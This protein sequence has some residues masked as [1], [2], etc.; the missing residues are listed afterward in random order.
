ALP[1]LL[2]G[3]GAPPALHS[4]PTR[5]SSDLQVSAVPDLQS[6]AQALKKQLPDLLILSDRFPA[7]SG[8]DFGAQLLEDYPFLPILLLPNEHSE[9]LPGEA[10]R[11]GFAGYLKPPLRPQQAQQVIAQTLERRRKQQAWI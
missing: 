6:A 4:F 10:L 8:L 5:R 11:R 3:S 9:N 2:Y 7:G 1:L